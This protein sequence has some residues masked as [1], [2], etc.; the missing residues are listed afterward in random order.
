MIGA[1]EALSEYLANG[2]N[3]LVA[4][5]DTAAIDESWVYPQQ[6][7]YA[8]LRGLY[9]GKANAPFE[10]T[11]EPG[12]V[13]EDLRITLEETDDAGEAIAPPEHG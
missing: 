13:F 12:S 8:Q 4:G 10:L 3:V 5:Q 6:W 7:W 11:G 9:Q 1:G 2:G